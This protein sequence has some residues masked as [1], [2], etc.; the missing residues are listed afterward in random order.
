M[1]GFQSFVNAAITICGIELAR[2]IRKGQFSFGRGCPPL[3]ERGKR[4]GKWHWVLRRETRPRSSWHEELG[5]ER[6]LLAPYAIF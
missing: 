1:A 6:W 2:R 5:R 3:A 4:D